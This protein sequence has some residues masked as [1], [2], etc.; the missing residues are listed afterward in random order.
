MGDEVVARHRRHGSHDL[1]RESVTADEGAG[2]PN[3]GLDIAQHLDSV[4]KH[5]HHRSVT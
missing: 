4:G 5:G 1:G 3:L 2:I